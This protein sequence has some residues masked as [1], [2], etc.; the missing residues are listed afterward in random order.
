MTFHLF[1]RIHHNAEGQF[2]VSVSMHI[3]ATKFEMFWMDSLTN[4]AYKRQ[5]IEQIMMSC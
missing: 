1:I 4:W 2:V 5:S 3:D